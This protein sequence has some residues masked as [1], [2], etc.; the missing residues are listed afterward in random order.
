MKTNGSVYNANCNAHLDFIVRGMQ[1]F[2]VVV[3]KKCCSDHPLVKFSSAKV[4][5]DSILVN[6]SFVFSKS[7]QDLN[8]IFI[9]F[10]Q[11]SRR[12]CRKPI[13]KKSLALVY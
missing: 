6:F 8:F 1:V 5:L 13:N 2:C 10:L 7:K 11:N 12:L 9:A 4:S 3:Q